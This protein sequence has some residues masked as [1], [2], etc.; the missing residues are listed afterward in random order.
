M[1]VYSIYKY[2][3]KQIDALEA[4]VFCNE[5]KETPLSLAQEVLD[6]LLQGEHPLNITKEGR[7]KV[8]VPLHNEVT[9]KRDRVTVLLVCNEKKLKYVEK[10]DDRELISHPGCYV[11]IDNREGIAQMAIERSPSFQSDPDKVCLLLQRAINDK[12]AAYRLRIDIRGRVDEAKFWQVV[13]RQTTEHQDR[14]KWIKF[15]YD[16]PDEQAGI[17]ATEEMK[18]MVNAYTRLGRLMG[19][20]RGQHMYNASK[21][22]SLHLDQTEEDMAQL[23][24]YCSTNAYDISVGFCHYGVYRY[25]CDERAFARLEDTVL[26]DFMHDRPTIDEKGNPAWGLRLWLDNVRQMFKDYKDVTPTKKTRKRKSKK[27]TA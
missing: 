13:Q 5:S 15:N 22:G 6:R 14:I 20:E 23:I 26:D 1:A 27:Q 16:V 18:V 4:M 9:F 25:G 3:I 2:T 12:L 17:D 7:E 21:M 8:L 24:H 10:K 11:I 19:A